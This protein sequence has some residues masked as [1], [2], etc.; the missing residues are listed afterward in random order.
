MTQSLL[1]NP[2]AFEKALQEA[3]D[4]IRPIN[5]AIHLWKRVFTEV[6]RAKLGGE[7]DAACR[8][9][10]LGQAAEMWMRLHGC[11]KNRA[12]LDV[13]HAL[14]LLSESNFVWLRREIGE[15]VTPLPP[16]PAPPPLLQWSS[17]DGT[18]KFHGT[19]VRR[20]RIKKSPTNPQKILDAFESAGWT[21]RIANPM[22]LGQQQLHEALRSLNR[23]LEG[24]RFHSIEGGNAIRW[25]TV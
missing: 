18:L 1:Q 19:V 12:V 4:R 11:T 23:D 6:D 8:Y 9:K 16:P 25:S 7:F 17:A 15:P 20:L 2:P 22:H 21:S 14:D 13:A 3:E 5:A 10:V 24:I